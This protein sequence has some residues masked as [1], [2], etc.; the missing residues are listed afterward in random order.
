M[1]L[2]T[3]RISH[4]NQHEKDI[5]IEVLRIT[6]CI[7]VIIIHVSAY[8]T[9]VLP[10]ETF[11]W[12]A[13]NFW[14]S[15]VSSAVPIFF[16]ISGAFMLNPNINMGLKKLKRKIIKLSILY[17]IWVVLY[18]CYISSIENCIP[19]GM[20][21][22][23]QV[24][25]TALNGGRY[26]LWFLPMLIGLYFFTPL[27]RAMVKDLN[28]RI[29]LYGIRVF[30][31]IVLCN[32][33]L[34]L[35]VIPYYQFLSNILNRFPIEALTNGGG[36]Y[37]LGYYIYNYDIQE[38]ACKNIYFLAICSIL[39]TSIVSGYIA[40]TTGT[41]GALHQNISITTFVEAIAIFLFFK[42]HLGRIPFTVKMQKGVLMISDLTL[43]VYVFHDII[44]TYFRHTGLLSTAD[45]NPL[46]SIPCIAA[47][48]FLV[49][50]CAV[51]I[52]KH[53]PVVKKW[54]V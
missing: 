16:M 28:K 1:S 15:V 40:V 49:S 38:K 3:K 11:L 10:P 17:V 22:L 37:L 30:I 12:Q 23:K 18:S 54:M 21:W 26:H 47:I 14:N 32:T 6:A 31:V 7:M 48:I 36:Y 34:E 27:L 19:L 41:L 5:S 42:K 25:I 29:F 45:F 2:N 4:S 52:L 13:M 50:L 33:V 46:V 53:I 8:N 51:W 9:Y 20:T 39:I 35:E 24:I 43:G 44:L